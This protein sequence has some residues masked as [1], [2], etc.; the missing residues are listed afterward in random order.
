MWELTKSFTFEAAHTLTGTTL[1]P[2]SEE[3][4]GHSFR[5]EVAVR[6]MPDPETGMLIDLGLLEGMLAEMRRTLDH[7]FLNRIEGLERPTLENITRFIFDRIEHIG[8]IARVTIYRDSCGETC[9]YYAPADH[10]RR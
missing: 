3:I 5:A 7:K 6:G 9:T 8:P 2:A 1:G 4:H 10:E